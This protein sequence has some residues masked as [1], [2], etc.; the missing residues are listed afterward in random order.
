M[1]TT[2]AEFEA[3]AL[4]DQTPLTSNK[5]T[6]I[7]LELQEKEDSLPTNRFTK[8]F[9]LL[10]LYCLVLIVY[11]FYLGYA[12]YWHKI[13]SINISWCEGLGFLLVVSTL[14]YTYL[15]YSF[16]LSPLADHVSF[17]IRFP[18]SMEK[19]IQSNG[20]RRAVSSII[21]I[22]CIIFLIIDTED[23][24]HRKVYLFVSSE[25]KGL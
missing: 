12:I 14:V 9:K 11:P 5:S 25:L 18:R 15:C 13:N 7:P 23:D 2:L 3:K 16:V 8:L 10:I 21:I 22:G 24:R 17:D 19:W 6:I 1:V 20:V 4:M